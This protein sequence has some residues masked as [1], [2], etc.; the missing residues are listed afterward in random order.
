MWFL[1]RG[2]GG[3]MGMSYPPAGSLVTQIETQRERRF[4]GNNARSIPLVYPGQEVLADQP[5]I[6]LELYQAE[7]Q[8]QADEPFVIPAGLRGQVVKTT[9]R[10]GVVIQTRAAVLAGNIGAGQQV[11]GFL[12]LW[13]PTPSRPSP[14]PAGAIL[15][16][17]GQASFAM[18][19]QAIASG[20]V[21]IVAGSIEMRDFEGFLGLDAFD[22][23]DSIDV[24]MAQV[25]LPPLT[26]LFTEG[27]GSQTMSS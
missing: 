18:L 3:T 2:G 7:G 8:T 6:R 1:E 25:S 22:L 12:T 16:I 26:L 27:F 13:Q 4:A 11:A 9:A 14:V 19:R 17:P 24:D 23:L 20:V 10:G 21:G 5:V 15:V